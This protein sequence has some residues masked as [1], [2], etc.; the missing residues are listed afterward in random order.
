MILSAKPSL[1]G[2]CSEAGSRIALIDLARGIALVA[3]VVYH[4]AWDLQFFRL[5]PVDVV[6]HPG[7]DAFAHLVAGTFLALVGVSLVLASRNGFSRAA[8]L[9]RLALI[10]AAALAVTLATSFATPEAYI[11]FGILHC[12]ALS[13]VLALPFLRTPILAVISMAGM[14]IALPQVYRAPVFNEAALRWIGLG[15][16]PPTTSDYVP[17]FP[18]FGLVLVGV[19][20]ARLALGAKDAT[21]WSRFQPLASGRG[22]AWA[23]RHSLAIYL[24]HQPFLFGALWTLLQV[25]GPNAATETAAFMRSC[26]PACGE[27][28]SNASV[29]RRICSCSADALR[30]DNLWR[31]VMDG[32]INADQRQRVSAA[33]KECRAKAR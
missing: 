27:A 3:M 8:F 7:W 1:A 28:G 9:K 2:P 17:I 24:V 14:V 13:S 11:F 22:L 4:G 20:G 12:I 32:Q 18:W 26:V 31:P 6:G 21:W 16:I 15:T 23:G 25:T 30:R 33:A 10:G 19:A 29:C 5:A